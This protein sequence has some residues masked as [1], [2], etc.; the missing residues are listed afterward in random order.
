MDIYCPVCSEPWDNDALHEYAEELEMKYSDVARTYRESGCG[1]AFKEWGITCE[2]VSNSRTRV[3]AALIEIM[4]DDMD[5]IMSGMED[6]EYLN[7]VND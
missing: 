1:E 4:G 7:L 5:G 3:M 2:K 6:A